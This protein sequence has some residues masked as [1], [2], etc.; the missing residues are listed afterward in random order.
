MAKHRQNKTHDLPGGMPRPEVNI[1]KRQAKAM[2]WILAAAVMSVAIA[3]F[4]L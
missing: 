4:W 2:L 3:S 1:S